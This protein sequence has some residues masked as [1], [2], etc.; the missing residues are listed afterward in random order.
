[1]AMTWLQLWTLGEALG[2]TQGK[3]AE[4]LRSTTRELKIELKEMSVRRDG[5]RIQRK[6]GV[7]SATFSRNLKKRPDEQIPAAL[8]KLA[9]TLKPLPGDR[10]ERP[11]PSI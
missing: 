5:Q 4:T 7:S 11:T 6:R 3:L 2:Y 10:W 1:M 9:R 8:E